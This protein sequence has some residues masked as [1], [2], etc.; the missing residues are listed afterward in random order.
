MKEQES[1]NKI[2]EILKK[3]AL[4]FQDDFSKQLDYYF[5]EE[6][7]ENEIIIHFNIIYGKKIEYLII[8]EKLKTMAD[9]IPN[10]KGYD[11]LNLSTNPYRNLK[12]TD[13]NAILGNIYEYIE[14]E[15][16]D[17]IN[18]YQEFGIILRNPLELK[19]IYNINVK[20]KEK[21]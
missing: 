14:K 6:K 17:E 19:G 12:Y 8:F 3:G 20:F 1:I 9:H 21:I 11:K 13:E 7:K 2:I 18:C 4:K 15:Q 10:V 5:I 16:V